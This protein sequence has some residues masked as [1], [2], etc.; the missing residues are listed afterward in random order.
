[1]TVKSSKVGAILGLIG[2]TILLIVGL[3]SVSMS[4]NAYHPDPYFPFFLPYITAFVTVTLSAFGLLGSL[5]VFRDTTMGYIFLLIAGIVGI[6]GT[7]LPIYIYDDGGYIVMNFLVSTFIYAD[8]ILMLVG[9]ILG[10]A[11][12]EKK[13]R[14]K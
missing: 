2:S 14:I 9:G 11:L 1:M 8:L 13:E 6:V 3:A 10:F 5:L 12:A 4:R 7:F